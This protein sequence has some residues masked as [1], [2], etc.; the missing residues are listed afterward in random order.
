[1]TTA[2]FLERR[3]A[4]A[5]HGATWQREAVAGATTFLAMAYITVVNPAILADAGMD[6]GA[7]FV[8]T[9]LAAAAGTLAMGLL[10]NYPIA[11]APGMGQNAF[12]TYAVVV[13]SGHPWQVAL[14]A[15][16]LSGVLFVLL[17]ALPV[18]EWL[19]NAIPRNL[20][21]GMAAG[22]GL[23]VAFVG[24][25]NAGIVAANEATDRKSVV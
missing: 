23:F 18:R 17:S 24:L 13:G 16:F 25:R 9:C 8:A 21:Y 11:L 19:V 7:V 3:F 12:F 5:A 10:A 1:M 2:D 4:L 14:G 22:I 20:K 15:V 6:F